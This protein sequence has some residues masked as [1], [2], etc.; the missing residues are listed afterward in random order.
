MLSEL[1]ALVKPLVGN[2]LYP[3]RIKEGATLPAAKW[4]VIDGEPEVTHD[5]DAGLARQVVQFSVIGEDYESAY[6]VLRNIVLT[7]SG[8]KGGTIQASFVGRNIDLIDPPTGKPMLIVD[9]S[10]WS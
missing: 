3:L 7:L 9:V 5:G 10:I 4:Q 2:R 1:I 8:Y 6:A